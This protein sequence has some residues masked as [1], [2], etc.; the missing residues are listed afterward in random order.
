MTQEFEL[1]PEEFGE[2]FKNTPG[3][4]LIDVRTPQ[5]YA[6]GHLPGAINVD[7]YNPAFSVEIEEFDKGGSYFVYCKAGGRS[8]M[9]GEIMKKEGF[10]DVHHMRGGINAWNGAVE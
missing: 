2:T 10:A 7:I 1:S 8:K 4:I 6:E 3:A 9:A 5:E